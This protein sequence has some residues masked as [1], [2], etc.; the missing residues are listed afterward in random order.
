MGLRAKKINYSIYD[1]ISE[2]L[3]HAEIR[4]FNCETSIVYKGHIPHA[5]YLLVSGGMFL[6]DRNKNISLEEGAVIGI[7]EVLKNAPFK[8]NLVIEKGS[9]VIIL[10]KST[11]SELVHNGHLHQAIK[12]IT[13]I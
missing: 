3:N 10:D 6:K 12:D 9:D 2:I 5:A 1:D 4:R 11:I 7:E 8:F 13:S